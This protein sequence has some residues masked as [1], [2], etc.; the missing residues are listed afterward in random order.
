MYGHGLYFA[1]NPAVSGQG[2]QYWQQFLGKFQGT[3]EGEAAREL[4]HSGFDR[5]KAIGYLERDL[6]SKRELGLDPMDPAFAQTRVALERLRSD[7]P[8]GPRTYEVNINADPAHF[9]VGDKPLAGQPEAVRTHFRHLKDPTLTGGDLARRI[10]G[11]IWAQE[12][13]QAGIPGIKYLDQGSRMPGPS[14]LTTQ[15]IQARLSTM[16]DDLASGRGSQSFLE[17]D[18]QPRK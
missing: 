9:L 1:E 2:G 18:Q 17:A 13:A 4:M 6:N 11:P 3:P 5:Q 10:E 15:Q 7:K 16:R 8:V 14:A 12:A